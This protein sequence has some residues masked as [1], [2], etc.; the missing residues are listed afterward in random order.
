MFNVTKV[1]APCDFFQK[2]EFIPRW[3]NFTKGIKMTNIILGDLL[4][5]GYWNRQCH[6]FKNEGFITEM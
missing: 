4:P 3:E 2:L 1:M 5:L 6:L